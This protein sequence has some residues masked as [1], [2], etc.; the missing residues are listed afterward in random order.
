MLGLLVGAFGLVIHDAFPS[1]AVTL[2]ALALA[3]FLVVV[4]TN[5]S[6]RTRVTGYLPARSQQ[7]PFSWLLSMPRRRVAFRWGA[8][9]GM[10]VMTPLVTPLVYSVFLAEIAAG[11]LLTSIAVGA[12]YGASKTGWSAIVSLAGPTRSGF[13]HEYRL[14]SVGA[15]VRIPVTVALGVL[16]AGSMLLAI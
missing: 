2:V 10:G 5:P 14:A 15:K 4:E 13:T 8:L 3:T 1:T 12:A 9:M 7:L 6:I 16:L 11:N